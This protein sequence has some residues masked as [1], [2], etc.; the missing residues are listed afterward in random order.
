MI[1]SL[2]LSSCKESRGLQ[3]RPKAVS[4]FFAAVFSSWLQDIYCPIEIDVPCTLRRPLPHQPHLVLG[5]WG[6]A[7]V[8]NIIISASSSTRALSSYVLLY[9]LLFK[10][11][12]EYLWLKGEKFY[13]TIYRVH[14]HTVFWYLLSSLFPP[15][16]RLL[17]RGGARYKLVQRTFLSLCVWLPSSSF[18]FL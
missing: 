7:A 15:L 6:V 18:F 3:G 17:Q 11:Y 14:I 4:I 1:L 12:T 5:T 10:P 8:L 16:L 13:S 2:P 9:C